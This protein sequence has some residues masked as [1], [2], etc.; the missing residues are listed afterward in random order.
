MGEIIKVTGVPFD[1]AKVVGVT[2]FDCDGTEI[3]GTTWP[4]AATAVGDGPGDYCAMLSNELALTIG[5]EYTARV[6]I[7]AGHGRH[8]EIDLTLIATKRDS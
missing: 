1:D 7:D 3:G 5:D 2:L 4:I 6:V 8:A